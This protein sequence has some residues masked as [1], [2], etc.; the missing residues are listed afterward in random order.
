[1]LFRSFSD[2]GDK[3]GKFFGMEISEV[4]ADHKDMVGA[5]S[6]WTAKAAGTGQRRFLLEH[7]FSGGELTRMGIELN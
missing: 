5:F 6:I 4:I 1:M 7:A 2:A 3:C